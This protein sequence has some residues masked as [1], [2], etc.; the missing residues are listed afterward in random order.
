MADDPVSS[1]DGKSRGSARPIRV[2]TLGQTVDEGV[3]TF[4]FHRDSLLG[5]V[6]A[7]DLSDVTLVVQDWAACSA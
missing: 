2:W 7:L 5:F 4:D 3:Y 1:G 6:R